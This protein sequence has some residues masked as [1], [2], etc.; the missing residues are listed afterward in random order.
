[1]DDVVKIAVG[2]F[3]GALAAAFTWEG[4]Q[5]IRLQIAAHEA[6]EELSRAT[7][8][9]KAESE[10]RAAQQEAAK[11][12]QEATQ[13]ERERAIA[14]TR[15]MNLQREREKA[16]AWKRYFT[17]SQS[18]MNDPNTMECANAH[19]RAKTEFEATYRPSR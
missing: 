14:E 15:Q 3:I 17:P 12:Q 4:I 16:E 2:V 10:R 13:R 11:D 9:A 1:M 7:A 6:N 5:T 8:R 18:C 19:I